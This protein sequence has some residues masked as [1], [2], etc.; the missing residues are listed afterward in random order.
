MNEETEHVRCIGQARLLTGTAGFNQGSMSAVA[1]GGIGGFRPWDRAKGKVATSG[2]TAAS[3]QRSLLV[4][5]LS[6]LLEI[7]GAA[8]GRCHQVI[9]GPLWYE[10]VSWLCCSAMALRY[11]WP[12]DGCCAAGLMGPRG[13]GGNVGG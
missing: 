11:G 1:G 12:A 5:L 7:C 2:V 4:S 13:G 6:R 9:T 3:L 8:H 10:L